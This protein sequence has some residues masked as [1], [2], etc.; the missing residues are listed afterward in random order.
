MAVII[1]DDNF[2]QEVTESDLPVLIDFW[3]TW[4]GPCVMMSPVIE[5]LAQEFEGKIKI[6]KLNVEENPQTSSKF[7]IMSI[8]AFKIFKKGEVIAEFVGAMSEKD[9]KTKI[10]E[11]L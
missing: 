1:S 2:Q 6:G 5:K 11:A 3:A 7:G 8:P 4:C 9:L 10:E